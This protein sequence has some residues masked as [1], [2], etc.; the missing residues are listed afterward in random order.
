VL[1]PASLA[2]ESGAA[3]DVLSDAMRVVLWLG[4]SLVVGVPLGLECRRRFAGD[5]EEVD[6]LHAER[7]RE[8][9]EIGK[10]VRVVSARPK[11]EWWKRLVKKWDAHGRR[12]NQILNGSK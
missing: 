2:A 5:Q 7:A 1:L 9:G 10:R 6:V 12:G 3:G 11:P 8:S 4:V